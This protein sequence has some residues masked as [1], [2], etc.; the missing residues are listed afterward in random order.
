MIQ[1]WVADNIARILIWGAVVAVLIVCGELDGLR[2]G[3]IAKQEALAQIAAERVAVV[4]KTVRVVQEADHAAIDS[5]THER[6]NLRVQ[7]DAARRSAPLSN[8][9]GRV[10]SGANPSTAVPANVNGTP[11]EDR[12]QNARRMLDDVEGA[13]L[14]IS[15]SGDGEIVKLRALWLRE[16]KLARETQP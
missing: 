5:L 1:S 16:R 6:D 9:A 8:A 10:C 12:L 7:L 15:S 14:A 13:I 3:E 11:P 4:V 2:R